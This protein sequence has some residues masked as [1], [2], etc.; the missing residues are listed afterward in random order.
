MS[1]RILHIKSNVVNIKLDKEGG[2][3][4]WDGQ[5]DRS[6]AARTPHL[7]RGV[8]FVF[9]ILLGGGVGGGSGITATHHL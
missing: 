3:A 4:E 9:I 5:V 7:R 2:G 8:I 1:T 6:E